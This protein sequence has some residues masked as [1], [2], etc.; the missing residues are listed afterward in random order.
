VSLAAKR[1]AA[2][3]LRGTY[4]VSERRA[5]R[6]LAFPR[7]SKRRQPGQIAQVVLVARIHALSERD[8]RFGYRKIYALLTAEQWRVSREMV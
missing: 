1:Q 2:L 6:V 5:C 7:S 3:Y 4:R 8:P